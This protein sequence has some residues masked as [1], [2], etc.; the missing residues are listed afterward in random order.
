M[1]H[2]EGMILYWVTKK[3]DA[4]KQFFLDL[5]LDVPPE[6]PGWAQVTPMFNQ[7]RGCM[8]FLLAFG[9]SLE[10]CTD[11]PPSGPLYI[12]IEGLEEERLRGL[13]GKYS[14]KHVRGLYGEN[15]YN[16]KHPDGGVVVAIP[17]TPAQQK[18]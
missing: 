8:I 11:V 5:G 4:M 17:K 15:H 18:D 10:E 12:Q 14:V 2:D 16:I 9:I 3:Y 7:G 1:E 6:H 13:E